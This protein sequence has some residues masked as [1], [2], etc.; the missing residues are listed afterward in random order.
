M[1][2]LCIPIIILSFSFVFPATAYAGVYADELG[3][4]LVE[5]TSQRDRIELVRW[6]FSAASLH[7]AVEPMSS[8]TNEQLDA[9]N[10]V[11]ANLVMKLLTD[12]CR[13][14][15][16]NAIQYEGAT[17]LQTAFSVLGQVAGTELFASPEVAAGLAGLEK[18]LDG[19][20]LKSAVGLK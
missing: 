8:V 14:E 7:P 19:E 15:T 13:S 17:T 12:S 1:K 9:A 11:I 16:A 3:K 20:K 18:H 10:K 6:M 2:P 4:C 5:S